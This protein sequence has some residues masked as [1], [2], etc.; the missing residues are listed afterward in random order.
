MMPLWTAKPHRR[1]KRKV[2]KDADFGNLRNCGLYNHTVSLRV[3]EL[4]SRLEKVRYLR[5]S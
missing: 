1:M 5:T 3:Q 4:E 2:N